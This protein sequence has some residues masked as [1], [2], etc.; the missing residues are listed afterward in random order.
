MTQYNSI[1]FNFQKKKKIRFP[2]HLEKEFRTQ[3]S[4]ICTYATNHSKQIFLP[5]SLCSSKLLLSG[6]KWKEVRVPIEVR[7]PRVVS[8]PRVVNV[9]RVLRDVSSGKRDGSRSGDTG[10][11]TR[12]IRGCTA[13]AGQRVRRLMLVW[14]DE[15]GDGGRERRRDDGCVV[16][17][18]CGWHFDGLGDL[19]HHGRVHHL[20]RRAVANL[21][22]VAGVR[23]VRRDCVFAGDGHNRNDGSSP[24]VVGAMARNLIVTDRVAGASTGDGAIPRSMSGCTGGL[25]IAGRGSRADHFV[26]GGRDCHR[27]GGI[28]N[29]QV[30][31][32]VGRRITSGHGSRVRNE[33]GDGLDGRRRIH[34]RDGGG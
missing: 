9:V 4:Y 21:R 30:A 10:A 19:N 32:V 12:R 27:G 13:P 18:V 14:L 33:C 1:Q 15:S 29:R 25:G 2:L 22:S 26:R 3:G 8:V 23:E 24:V 7:S 34:V 31:G 5:S 16:S 11:G 6:R 20:G 17:F 28:G